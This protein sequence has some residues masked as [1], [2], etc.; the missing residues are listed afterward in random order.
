[1]HSKGPEQGWR[2]TQ[3]M[4]NYELSQVSRHFTQSVMGAGTG[5]SA[6]PACRVGLPRAVRE[7]RAA[8][9]DTRRLNS[10]S[11]ARSQVQD[12]RYYIGQLCVRRDT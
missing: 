6:R 2:I 8:G 3:G 12:F 7:D 9:L 10:K 4:L 11:G 1:M 5:R